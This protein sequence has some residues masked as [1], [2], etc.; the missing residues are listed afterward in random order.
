MQGGERQYHQ[1]Q[2]QCLHFVDKL[3]PS[4]YSLPPIMFGKQTRVRRHFPRRG[5]KTTTADGLPTMLRYR[6]E[7]FNK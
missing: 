6:P 2:L 7:N 3:K 5:P 1:D 4:H